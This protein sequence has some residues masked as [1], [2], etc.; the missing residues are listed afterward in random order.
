MSK[1]A[2][3]VP[4]PVQH[5]FEEFGQ[6]LRRARLRRSMSMVEMAERTGISRD[7]LHRLE[8]GDASISI[9]ALLTVLSILGLEADLDRVGADDWIG[10][11]L[12]DMAVPGGRRRPTQGDPVIAALRR[13]DLIDLA[14]RD[15]SAIAESKAAY[16]PELGRRVGP[17]GA[18]R[19]ADE[20]RRYVAL[21]R[22]DWP[23]ADARAADLASHVQL[24]ES[25]RRVR[26]VRAR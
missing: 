25:L 12:Q 10:R 19:V 5:R 3:Q 16:W 2:R 11:T 6:R 17:D 21:V 18:F 20:M 26:D 15:W 23:D 7:T 9:G 22:P 4:P 24:G 8:R 13:Q 14:Q 1:V